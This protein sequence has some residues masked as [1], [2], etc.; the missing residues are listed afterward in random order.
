MN[1]TGPLP[2]TV[3]SAAIMAYRDGLHWSDDLVCRT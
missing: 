1:D 2:P 3:Q